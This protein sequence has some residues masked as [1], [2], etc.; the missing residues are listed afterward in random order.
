MTQVRLPDGSTRELTA[1]A[2]AAD[3]AAAIGPGL[4]KAAVAAKVDGEI[5]DLSRPL[6]DGADVALLTRKDPEALE[7]LRH[8]AA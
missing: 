2:T 1:G 7:V 3:L 4:A 5:V 6:P 8:S